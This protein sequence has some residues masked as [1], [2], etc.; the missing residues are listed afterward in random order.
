MANENIIERS[1]AEYSTLAQ[2]IEGELPPF[3]KVYGRV[4]EYYESLPW[5]ALSFL[6]E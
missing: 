4:K 6:L 2:E 1:R 3:D 5:K